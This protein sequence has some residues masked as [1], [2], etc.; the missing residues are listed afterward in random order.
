MILRSEQLNH[1]ASEYQK[2]LL[3]SWAAELRWR[4][5]TILDGVGDQ[6]VIQV[7][8]TNWA[9]ADRLEIRGEEQIW[10]YVCLRFDMLGIA[11]SSYRLSVIASILRNLNWPGAK[12]LDFIGRHVIR[13]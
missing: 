8:K 2:R 7:I 1:L 6:E 9:E 13:S 12:R 11:G 10:R 5:P 4:Y 3:L